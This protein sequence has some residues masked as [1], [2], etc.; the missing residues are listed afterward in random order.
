MERAIQSF[1][2]ITVSDGSD[3]LRRQLLQRSCNLRRSGTVR[4]ARQSESAKDNSNRLDT[5]TQQSIQR[6]A[7]LPRYSYAEWTTGH[8]PE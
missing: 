4:Q 6:L 3:C 5:A 7:I 1:L 8:S 2:L